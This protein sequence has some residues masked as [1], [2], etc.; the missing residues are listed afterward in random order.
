MDYLYER[1]VHVEKL[2]Y[3]HVKMC[4]MMMEVVDTRGEWRRGNGGGREW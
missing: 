4:K 3:K 1:V 2:M